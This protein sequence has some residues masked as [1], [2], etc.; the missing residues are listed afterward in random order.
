MSLEASAQ[1]QTEILDDFY[2]E[3]DGL[4]ATLRIS[5]GVLENTLAAG[6]ADVAALETLYRC[7]HSLKGNAAIVGLRVAEQLA[8]AAEDLMR[9]ISRRE[10]TLEPEHLDLL[11]AANHRLEQTITSHRL[12]QPLPAIADLLD[13]LGQ[14]GLGEPPVAPSPPSAV[15]S[16]GAD[17]SRWHCTFTPSSELNERGINIDQVRTRLSA[18]GAI[19]AAAPTVRPDGGITFDFSVTLREA[20]VDLPLWEQDGLHWQPPKQQPTPAD[21]PAAAAPEAPFLFAPSRIVRVDLARLD[22]LMRITGEMVICR[23]RLESRLASGNRTELQEVNLSLGRSLRELREAITRVRLVPVAEIFSHLPF[24]VRDLARDT[25]KRV[26]LALEGEQTEIDKYL[27]E[28]LKE[29]LLHLVR[30]AVSHGVESPADRLARHK[31]AE[32]TVLLR[33]SIEGQTVI[34]HVRDDGSGIDPAA[35]TAQARASGVPVSAHP[36]DRELLEVI[37]RHGFST[38]QKADRTSGRGVGM[39][40]VQNTV[41][42]LGGSLSLESKPGA[43]TQFTLR[44][45]LSLLIAGTFIVSA[46]S[47]T[48]AVP[49]GIV[50]EILQISESEIRTIQQTEVISYRDG[51][52]PLRRLRAMFGSPPS[53]AAQVPVLVVSS[54]RGLAGLVVDRVHGQREVVVRTMQ[55]PLIQVPG[56][57]GATELGDGRPVLIID[58][59]AITSGAVRP[60]PTAATPVL[61]EAI[62]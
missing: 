23:S 32:A 46:A 48:C 16:P 36:T 18:L 56:F 51:V 21:G 25:G 4:H 52:L 54:E 35:I 19:V 28:R 12:E 34:I 40:V 61:P 10:L 37:C 11:A 20:P 42:E 33:A 22:E 3:C 9:R 45:P 1:L 17:P 27:V 38:R 31:P 13:R 53:P 57:T 44:L 50:E 24:V 60:H 15:D 30:N 58:P 2:A 29:P 5:L 8:H 39:D 7:F 41:R 14:Y 55:D 49:Q 62:P 6:Q 26:R 47:Q 43:W 59:A